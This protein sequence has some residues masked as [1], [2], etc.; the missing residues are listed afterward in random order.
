[1]ALRNLWRARKF[2][3]GSNPT[4]YKIFKKM[5]KELKNIDFTLLLFGR[6]EIA[7]TYRSIYRQCPLSY[8]VKKSLSKNIF[9]RLVTID[10]PTPIRFSPSLPT[11]NVAH[12]LSDYS[13]K[14]RNVPT[15]Y[16][17]ARFS[18]HSDFWA[19]KGLGIEPF[20]DVIFRYDS[21]KITKNR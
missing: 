10:F 16:R 17:P 7:K 20:E 15:D 13:S 1:M 12:Y 19:N 6:I 9:I 4:F 8:L 5:G 18:A 11:P 2:N 21:F 3:G 14:F